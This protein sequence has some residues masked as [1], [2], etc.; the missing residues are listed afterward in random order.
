MSNDQ[1][2]LLERWLEKALHDELASKH[3]LKH[4]PLILD[5]ACFH[6]QQAVEKYF[7]AFLVFKNYNFPK[8]HNI[9]ALQKLCIKLDDDF[10][11]LDVKD[12]DD[13]AVEIRYPDEYIDPSLKNARSYLKM[14]TQ[15]K[16]LVLKKIKK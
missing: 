12:L 5:T 2:D 9:S 14:V 16:K 3:L 7:K 8:T 13:Y 4:K 11:E 10:K 1:R 15:V 6:C